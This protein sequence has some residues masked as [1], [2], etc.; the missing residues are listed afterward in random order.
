MIF[1]IGTDILKV[2][3]VE[4]AYARYGDRFVKHLFMP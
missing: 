4:A 2:E 1:G 3:R